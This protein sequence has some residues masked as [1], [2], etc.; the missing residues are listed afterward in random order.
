MKEEA[1]QSEKWPFAEP[2]PIRE[3]QVQNAVNFL[4]HPKVRGTPMVQRFSFLERKGLSREEIDEAFR[5]CPDPPSSEA[6]KPLVPSEGGSHQAVV[7]AQPQPAQQYTSQAAIVRS[8][9]GSHWSHLIVGAGL[10]ATAGAGTAYFFQKVFAPKLRAWV[11][12]V[13]LEDKKATE[14]KEGHGK[15]LKSTPIEEAVGAA[16]AATNAAAAA[17]N[18]VANSSGEVPKLQAE[19]WQQITNL[20][21][22]LDSKTEELKRTLTSMGKDSDDAEAHLVAAI[23]ARMEGT[24]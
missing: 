3:D 6:T 13:I 4:S 18:E 9:L 19:E 14:V 7:L 20:L 24:S 12:D 5:R 8:R 2:Q 22:M 17:A 16:V 15:A 11:R 1:S 21:K 10:I 23:H